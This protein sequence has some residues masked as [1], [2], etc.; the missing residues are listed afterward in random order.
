MTCHAASAT[1]NYTAWSGGIY[2]HAATDTNCSTCHNNTTALGLTT[3]PHIPTAALQ[4]S[5]CHVNT[6]T[7]FT[8]Y[9]MTHVRRLDA[10]AA[11]PATTAHIRARERRARS[12]TASYPGHVATGRPRLRHLPRDRSRGLFELVRRHVHASGDRHELLDLP[13][14]YDRDSD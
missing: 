7:S 2:T 9:T 8:T 11:T 13:Q 5:N 10:C 3:P 12:G 1:G 6:A 14:Q 4:C